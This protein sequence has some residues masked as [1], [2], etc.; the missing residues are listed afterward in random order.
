MKHYHILND[1][2]K[3]I[4]MRLKPV[5][6]KPFKICTLP[7]AWTGSDGKWHGDKYNPDGICINA[8]RKD[9]TKHSLE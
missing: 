8:C 9:L 2:G 3:T 7:F 4:D 5:E 1:K 6:D